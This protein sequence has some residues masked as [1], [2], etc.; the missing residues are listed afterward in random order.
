MCLS[1]VLPT[2]SIISPCHLI[3][4]LSVKKKFAMT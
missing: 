1:T 4:I 2:V 3:W